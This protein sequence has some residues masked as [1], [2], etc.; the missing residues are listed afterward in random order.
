MMVSVTLSAKPS[1]PG[2]ATFTSDP[3][4]GEYEAARDT[5]SASCAL[6]WSVAPALSLTPYVPR[7]ADFEQPVPPLDRIEGAA[8]ASVAHPDE[9]SNHFAKEKQ[10]TYKTRPPTSGDHYAS[11]AES[12]TGAL[13]E[14]AYVETP[15][16]SRAVHALEHG[17]IEVQY[18]P[19][20]PEEDQ[21]AIKGAFDEDPNGMLLFPNADMPY[22]VATTAWTNLLG[23]KTFDDGATL[24][25][26]RAFRDTFRGRGPEPVPL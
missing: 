1:V 2:D 21:L 24:D 26:I 3:R 23:C 6:L 20:L 9:G 4:Q 15:P 16:L 8:T 19:D 14:G 18:A 10:G 7:A 5:R 12:G 13:S 17:R 25:A 11:P 22:E